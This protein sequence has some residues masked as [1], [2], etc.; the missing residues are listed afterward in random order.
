MTYNKFN[1]TNSSS[2][3]IFHFIS[4]I[5]KHYALDILD[6]TTANE[7]FNMYFDS[8]IMRGSDHQSCISSNIAIR[9][10]NMGFLDIYH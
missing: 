9:N 3:T 2:P 6:F 5:V 4:Q 10:V 7:P 1:L 8:S